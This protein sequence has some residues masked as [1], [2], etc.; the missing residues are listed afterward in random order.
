MKPVLVALAN[1]GDKWGIF[2][3]LAAVG[4]YVFKKNKIGL[5]LFN[6]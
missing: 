5:A 6:P 2:C 4:V 1:V 3:D